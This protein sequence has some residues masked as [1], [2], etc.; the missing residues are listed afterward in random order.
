MPL[1]LQARLLRVLQDRAVTPLGGGAQVPIDFA[2]ICATHR[3][4]RRLVEDGDFRQDLYFRIAQYTVEL[5]ALRHLPDRTGI[6]RALWQELGGPEAGIAMTPAC[7]DRLVHH[8]WPGNF[9]QL[10]G[11]L[12]ALIALAEPDRPI[13]PEALPADLRVKVP[14]A[15]GAASAGDLESITNAAIRAA[16]D[17]CG[18]N[19]SR[20]ARQLRVHRSTIYRRLA[21]ETPSIT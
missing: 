12:R 2:L 9:R 1:P 5:P 8:D 20:V 11:T 19:V 21:S 17:E 15:G 7:E 18:G 14:V 3:T 13:G 4:L 6:V 10:T 16:L